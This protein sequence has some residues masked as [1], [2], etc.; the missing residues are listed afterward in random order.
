MIQ[1]SYIFN[2]NYMNKFFK[3]I[4]IMIVLIF[5]ILFLSYII[6]IKLNTQT[7][8]EITDVVFIGNSNIQ[9]ALNDSLIS[10]K[11]N[12]KC[13]NY[14][15]GGQSLFWTVTSAKKHKL[16]GVNNFII[17]LDEVTY[18]TGDK[19]H[20]NILGGK[21]MTYYKNFLSLNDWSILFN[22][23]LKFS[24][25]SLFI[26]P[27]PTLNFIGYFSNGKRPF[28]DGLT[29]FNRDEIIDTND[30][31]L[32][33]LI[34]NNPSSNFIIIKSPFHP[35]YYKQEMY[36]KNTQHLINRLNSFKIYDNT[37]VLDYGSFL[38][39]D[40]FF[41]DHS[42]LNY[43]GAKVFSVEVAKI[44]NQTEFFKR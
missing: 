3:N 24:I 12:T 36:K 8:L 4:I 7:N 32:H 28:Y 41:M 31:I 9:H 27:K 34:K 37:L 44:I 30:E 17:S 22:M 43:H 14:G 1:P 11:L 29:K 5:T 39:D 20:D 16:Q 10:E 6:D 15:A 18:T 2:F 38:K 40:S 21:N 33:D 25:K 23:D 26:L 13:I 42:H 19:T 35:N